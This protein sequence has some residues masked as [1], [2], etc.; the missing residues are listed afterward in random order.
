MGCPRCASRRSETAPR[1]RAL[2]NLADL[3]D[4]LAQVLLGVARVGDPGGS[5]DVELQLHGA[6]DAMLNAFTTP[7]ARS[8]RSLIRC[9]RLISRKRR[10]AMRARVTRKSG[11]EPTSC[12]SVVAQPASLAST[13]NSINSTVLPTPRSPE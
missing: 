8:T 9:L 12:T 1:L 6:G 4:Q 3:H 5:L 2:G 13:S 10:A 11:C 7:S